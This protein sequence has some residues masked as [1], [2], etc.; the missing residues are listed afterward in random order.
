MA[1]I[2]LSSTYDSEQWKI[3]S[4]KILSNG[5][6]LVHFE[7][8]GTAEFPP[9]PTDPVWRVDTS[10]RMCVRNYAIQERILREEGISMKKHVLGL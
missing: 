1:R 9:L 7:N 4:E 10:R 2:K 8:G 6:K 3:A 5:N